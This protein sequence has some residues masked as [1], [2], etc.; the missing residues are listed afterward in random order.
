MGNNRRTSRLTGALSVIRR[1][2]GNFGLQDSMP[3]LSE[4]NA[5][6]TIQKHW[7]S[8][9]AR[10]AFLIKVNDTQFQKEHARVERLEKVHEEAKDQ[11][12]IF[13]EI[14]NLDF[15]YK[16]IEIQRKSS[17]IVIQRAWRNFKKQPPKTQ[18]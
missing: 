2:D 14:E 10:K 3:H 17:A 5:A 11:R 9:R 6:V 7:R 1:F 4:W 18:P 13:D 8:Y 15:I 12:D 16:N